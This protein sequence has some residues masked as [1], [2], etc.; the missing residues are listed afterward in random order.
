MREQ[1][2]KAAPFVIGLVL[3]V[4]AL[5]VLRVEL[6]AFTWRDLSADVWH[7]PPGRLFLAVVLTALN[8]VTLT[9]YDLLAFAYIGKRL[10]RAHIAVASF[11]AY[12]ISNN[13]GFGVVSG[14]SVRYRFYTRWGVTAEDLSRIVFSYSVTFWLGLFALGG[15]SLVAAPIPD[16]TGVP[17]RAVLV[18]IGWVLMAVPPAY[19]ALTML[20]REP[21]RFR[22]FVL[23]LPRPAIAV[24][25]LAISCADWLLVGAVLYVLLPDHG[26]P[27]FTFLAHV[28]RRHPPRHGQPC[29]WRSRRLRRS[30][31]PAASALPLVG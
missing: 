9:G 19:V 11:L 18:A 24:A 17:A 4:A 5:E 23:P 7:T 14:A 16:I 25:Q 30:D 13:V 1:I 12:A 28:S 10:R 21:F 8:Y 27:F 26:P 31:G 29:P 3:F 2:K 20:R 6:S 22:Q 15:L